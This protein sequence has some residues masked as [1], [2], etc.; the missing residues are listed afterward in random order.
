V[1]QQHQ[2]HSIIEMAFLFFLMD[3]RSHV[4]AATTATAVSGFLNGHANFTCVKDASLSGC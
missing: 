2:Q 4:A 1:N 3:Y